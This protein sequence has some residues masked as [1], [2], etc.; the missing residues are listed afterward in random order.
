MNSDLQAHSL[1][2]AAAA[3]SAGGLHALAQALEQAGRAGQWDYFGELLPR[4][5]DEFRSA[6]ALLKRSGRSRFGRRAPR[7]GPGAGTGR[8]GWSVELFRRT[9]ATHGR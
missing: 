7:S 8:Q 9:S 4:T 2:G 3:V 1:K 6:G 5:A